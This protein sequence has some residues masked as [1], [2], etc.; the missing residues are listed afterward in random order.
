MDYPANYEKIRAQYAEVIAAYEGL[1]DLVTQAGPLNLEH[2]GPQVAQHHR[3]IR[4]R[5]HAGKIKHTHVL[6]RQSHEVQPD[7]G[8]LIV[9]FNPPHATA[10]RRAALYAPCPPR[11]SNRHA[12]GEIGRTARYAAGDDCRAGRGAIRYEP[13]PEHRPAMISRRLPP[14]APRRKHHPKAIISARPP[15]MPTFESLRPIWPTRFM[16]P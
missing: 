11:T 5:E 12:A 9:S 4:P 3:T 16:R 13:R 15:C 2:F 1:G 7:N 10:R 14:P 8:N 6:K